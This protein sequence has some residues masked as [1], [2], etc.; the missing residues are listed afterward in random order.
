MAERDGL[1]FVSSLHGAAMHESIKAGQIVQVEEKPSIADAL[2]GPVPQDTAY[3]F[4]LC[5]RLV[6]DFVQVSDAAIEDAMTYI[7]RHENSHAP[8]HQ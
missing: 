6:D 3:T 8:S 5:R 4:D 1:V 2:P 7:L